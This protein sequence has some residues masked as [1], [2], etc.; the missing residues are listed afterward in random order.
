MMSHTE[1]RASGE[2][3][4][5]VEYFAKLINPEAEQTLLGALFIHNRLYAEVAR[6]LQAE[7]F[8]NSLHAR[9]FSAIGKLLDRGMQAN[10]VTLKN[11]F[12][13]DETLKPVGGAKYLAT[14]A[15]AGAMVTQLQDYA[16]IIFDLARRRELAIASLDVLD[17]RPDAQV[18]DVLA[19]LESCLAEIKRAGPSRIELVDPTT[20]ADLAVPE[21]QWLVPDWIPMRR[22]TG[23]YGVG[24]SGKTLLMQMLATAC[25]IGVPFLGLP[26]RRCRSILLY[27]EDDLDEMH[28]R[29]ADINR[30]F[31][32]T[33]ADLSDMRWLPKLGHEN[34]LMTF[35]NGLAVLTP[36]FGELLTEAKSFGAALVVTDTLAD[37]FGGNEID[38]G[39]ARRFVQEGLGRIARE[40]GAAVIAAGHPSVSGIKNE[41]GESGSTGWDGAFRSRLYLHYPKAEEGH[42]PDRS[43]RILTRKKSNWAKVGESILLRWRNGV[44]VVDQPTGII[45]SIERRTADRVFLELLDATWEENQRVSSRSHS[46]SNYA[47]KLFAKRPENRE[48]FTK[49]DFECAMQRLFAAGEII[50]LEYGRPSDPRYRIARKSAAAAGVAVQARASQFHVTH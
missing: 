2:R 13:E 23:L 50:D 19:A 31:G 4:A 47:P 3:P 45:G 26:V 15:N 9:I 24:G 29:Q 42:E 28:L 44:F 1:L 6:T 46:G 36:L 32:C 17:A 18:G 37:V 43:E 48:R 5:R 12:D 40:T 8:G 27:C 25:A 21:R 41:T 34:T 35:E 11:L 10:P 49:A 20:L 38:R 14:L 22:A 16:T 39:Q 7:H 33:W 30:L